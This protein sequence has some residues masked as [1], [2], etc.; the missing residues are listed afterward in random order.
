[1]KK[2]VCIFPYTNEEISLVVNCPEEYEIVAAISTGI[3]AEGLDIS[4]FANR[5][6][7]GIKLSND[8]ESGIRNCD[9]LLISDSSHKRK[10]MLNGRM[11]NPLLPI[12]Y[13]AIEMAIHSGKEI[14]CF[15]QL[16]IENQ[17][18]YTK[19]AEKK[20]VSF[21]YFQQEALYE[22]NISGF[23]KI[24]APVIFIGEMV[25]NCDG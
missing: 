8:L 21:Q 19:M 6:K 22:N 15:S 3:E 23:V 14:F 16:D 20:G 10:E 4:T 13:D 18:K 2:K 24:N 12:L 7:I 11:E 17:K 25:F 1:M 5:D 9:I